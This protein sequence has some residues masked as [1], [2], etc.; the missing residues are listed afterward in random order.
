MT[1]QNNDY[2]DRLKAALKPQPISD[3]AA[4]A[5]FGIHERADEKRVQDQDK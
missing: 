3:R 5:L 4:R 1:N 2:K